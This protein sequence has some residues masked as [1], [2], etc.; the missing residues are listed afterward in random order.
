[1][2]A[3]FWKPVLWI[4]HTGAPRRDLPEAL[5]NWHTVYTRYD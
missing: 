1:M 2:T 5:G 3:C 4:C